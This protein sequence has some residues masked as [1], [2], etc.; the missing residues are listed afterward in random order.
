MRLRMIN[1]LR[2]ATIPLPVRGLG[3]RDF[4]PRGTGMLPTV[5]DRMSTRWPP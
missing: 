2:I 3:R 4:E 5:R 1:V